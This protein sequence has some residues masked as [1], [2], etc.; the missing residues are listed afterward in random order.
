MSNKL[1]FHTFALEK[2]FKGK[3]QTKYFLLLWR[4]D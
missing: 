3:I 1:F 4:K 2:K